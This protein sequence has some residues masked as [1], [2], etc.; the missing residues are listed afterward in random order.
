MA[1]PSKTTKAPKKQE[2]PDVGQANIDRAMIDKQNKYEE[3]ISKK[4]G[5]GDSPY[6]K[7]SGP[8]YY[9]GKKCGGSVKGY[10][11]GGSASRGDGCAVKGH[12]KGR[13]I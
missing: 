8:D 3:G 7:F 4:F 9:K 10:A 2:E 1:T 12:T 6:E 13:M 5:I 11:K